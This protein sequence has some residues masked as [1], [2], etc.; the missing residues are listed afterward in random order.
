[1]SDKSVV[2]IGGGL[3]GLSAAL[4]LQEAGRAVEI[5]EGSNRVGG[6]VASDHIDGF[7]LDRGFQL[8]NA[9]YPEL[10]RLD[11]IGELDF[12]VASRSIDISL[13]DKRYLLSDP[14]SN[15]FSALNSKTGTLVEKLKFVQYL[16]HSARNENSVEAELETVGT[17]Y[18]RVL[19]PFLSG[20]FLADPKEISAVQGKELIR[21]FISGKPGLPRLGAGALPAILAKKI[22]KIHLNSQVD[23]ISQFSGHEVIVATD[24]TTSA[25]LLDIP[26]VPK[27][28]SCT[29]WYHEVPADFSD[30][31]R[32]LLDGQRRGPVLNSIVISNFVS[33]YAPAGRSLLSTTTIE[34]TSESEVRR[35]L[36]LLWGR[37]TQSWP[38]IAKYEIPKALPIFTPGSSLATTSRI[39]DDVYIAGDFRTSAS[40]NG[41]L[42]SG[43]LAA[44]ELLNK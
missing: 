10:K 43:R 42:L 29:T 33:S 19:R 30:S 5:Y 27:L 6:R 18:T 9:N 1:M 39:S 35:H 8:I 14:R 4:T 25:Q 32:L 12:Q 38:L 16:L 41:A 34:H 7:I 23:S 28:A 40:Q 21:S 11:V 22:E 44:Q 37:E 3:A 26:N 15:P 13:G 24:L 36:A 17:L 20:V 31:N 2:V